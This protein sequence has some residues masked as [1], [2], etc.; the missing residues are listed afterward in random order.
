MEEFVVPMLPIDGV[1]ATVCDL[2][3][4]ILEATRNMRSCKEDA[5]EEG[6]AGSGASSCSS[7]SSDTKLGKKP[8]L[9]SVLHGTRIN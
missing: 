8:S 9:Y 2:L 7:S 5:D 3:I 1:T 4:S 6:E